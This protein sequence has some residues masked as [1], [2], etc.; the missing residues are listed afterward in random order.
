MHS[1]FLINGFWILHFSG[2]HIPR[3]GRNLDSGLLKLN[4]VLYRM[5]SGFHFPGFHIPE[6]TILKIRITDFLTGDYFV[7]SR[8][9]HSTGSRKYCSSQQ[10]KTVSFKPCVTLIMQSIPAIPSVH[11]S[12]TQHV[13]PFLC[14]TGRIK[15]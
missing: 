14:T 3:N 13:N 6:A 4:C 2:F 8:E 10:C 12:R 11:Q 9:I 1:E 15:L 5:S 7:T